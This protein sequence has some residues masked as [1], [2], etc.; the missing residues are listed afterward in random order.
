MQGRGLGY[1]S[2]TLAIQ[3]VSQEEGTYRNL[4]YPWVIWSFSNKQALSSSSYCLKL[5]K[6]PAG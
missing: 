1:S 3:L 6:G 2:L 5:A 4:L